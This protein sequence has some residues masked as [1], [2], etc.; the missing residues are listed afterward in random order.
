[1]HDYR[2]PKKTRK[3]AERETPEVL[4]LVG[5]DEW[6]EGIYGFQHKQ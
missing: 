2:M 4:A 1:M 3:P 6:L 5:F